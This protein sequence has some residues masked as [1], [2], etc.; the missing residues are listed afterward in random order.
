MIEKLH[1][2]IKKIES[3]RQRLAK[4]KVSKAD[5]LKELEDKIKNF[6]VYENVDTEKLVNVLTR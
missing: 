3:D 1:E 2:E 5:R 6:E 4:Y